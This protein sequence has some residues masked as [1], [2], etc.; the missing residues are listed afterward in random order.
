MSPDSLDLAALTR[1]YLGLRAGSLVGLTVP[2]HDVEHDTPYG[3]V[4][5]LDLDP[6]AAELSRAVA[7]D[8]MAPFVVDHPEL[9]WLK[10]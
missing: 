1:E 3:P 4:P 10:P 2:F 9:V 8:R 7:E 6:G 5:T